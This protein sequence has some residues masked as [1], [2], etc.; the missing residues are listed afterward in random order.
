MVATRDTMSLASNV[1]GFEIFELWTQA[2]GEKL[3]CVYVHATDSIVEQYP[4]L[5]TGHYPEQKSEH[6][7][8]PQVINPTYYEIL[9]CSLS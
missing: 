5:I 6:K 1:L 2:E 7:L 9:R 8:S 3:S 4:D